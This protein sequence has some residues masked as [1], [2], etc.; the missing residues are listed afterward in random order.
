MWTRRQW[1][2]SCAGGLAAAAGCAH[3]GLGGLLRGRE[4]VALWLLDAGLGRGP[5]GGALVGLEGEGFVVRLLR[6]PMPRAVA[7]RAG[8]LW[9]SV[10]LRGSRRGPWGLLELGP[11]GELL[12]Q[13][14][15]V[16]GAHFALDSEGLPWV[17]SPGPKLQQL[18]DPS[19]ALVL[20]GAQLLPPVAQG[21]GVALASRSGE[22][23]RI[24]GQGVRQVTVEARIG[25]LTPAEGGPRWLGQS[26]DGRTLLGQWGRVTSRVSGWIGRVIQK[27]G[28]PT[29]APGLGAELWIGAGTRGQLWRVAATGR[30][31]ARCECGEQPRKLLSDGRGGVWA[32]LPGALARVDRQGTLGPGQGGFGS[33]QDLAP[34]A[35]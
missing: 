12:G 26:A 31:L 2:G 1:L 24:D 19:G 14:R 13:R 11:M 23:F 32:V 3:G 30:L 28:K 35:G 22:L 34:V 6:L 27:S 5:E 29:L 33:C 20:S 16:S 18:W 9:V 8:R 10:A 7:L 21:A 15:I 17:L 4:P 25:A